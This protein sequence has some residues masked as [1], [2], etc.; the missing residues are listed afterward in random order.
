MVTKNNSGQAPRLNPLTAVWT[1][2]LISPVTL[3]IYR[4]RGR[5][6]SRK[7]DVI[8]RYDLLSG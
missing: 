2:F 4:G 5:H 7:P 6:A 8:T 1:K 3:I